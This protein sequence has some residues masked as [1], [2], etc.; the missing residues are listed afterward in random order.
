LLTNASVKTFVSVRKSTV[1]K[2]KLIINNITAA[3]TIIDTL[4]T[5]HNFALS[6]CVPPN[7]VLRALN[8]PT[9]S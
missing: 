7:C 2:S 1:R 3:N 9:N 8:I 5:K 4:T 6:K